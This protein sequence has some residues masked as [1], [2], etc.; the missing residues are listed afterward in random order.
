ML[1]HKEEKLEHNTTF[2]FAAFVE[3]VFCVRITSG[4]LI[5]W[6]RNVNSVVSRLEISDPMMYC[7][8]D[9]IRN[10][11]KDSRSIQNP[12]SPCEDIKNGEI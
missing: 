2:L 3:L 1:F 9:I 5:S 12:L 7:Q 11:V 10:A 8:L 6:M 4:N